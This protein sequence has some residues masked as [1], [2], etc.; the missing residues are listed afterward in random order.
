MLEKLQICMTLVTNLRG[1]HMLYLNT[2][3]L[4]GCGTVSELVV[5]LMEASVISTHILVKKFK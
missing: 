3:V 1:V 2:L 4:L 5:G